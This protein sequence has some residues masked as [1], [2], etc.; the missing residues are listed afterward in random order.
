MLLE[1]YA[2]YELTY[3]RKSNTGVQISTNEGIWGK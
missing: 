2:V 3:L 1:T